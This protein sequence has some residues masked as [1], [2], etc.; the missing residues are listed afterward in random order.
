MSTSKQ[1]VSPSRSI[2]KELQF[3]LVGDFGAALIMGLMTSLRW[4]RDRS[5]EQWRKLAAI[6]RRFGKVIFAFWHSQLLMPAYLGRNMGVRILISA[7]EDGEYIARVVARLGFEP[8]R[9]SAT[10]GGARA[11]RELALAG[12]ERDL[13]VT[14][15]GPVGPR[16]HV[17]PG[18]IMLAQVSGLPIV[19][20][21][22]VARHSIRAHS[23][24]RFEVPL[25]GS[26][27]AFIVGDPMRVDPDIRGEARQ[28]ACR[29]LERTL[30]ELTD[31]VR[32]MVGLGP[33][34]GD[35]ECRTKKD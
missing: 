2:V 24:D 3:E 10:R 6:R 34:N 27:A 13:A 29:Q 5:H 21:A 15:D 32:H 11:L 17:Q 20:I 25:P 16:H 14:P 12:R 28:Q 26:P 22:G 19:P 33:E 1:P 31:R 7:S 4:K 35:A 9:G 18:S 23:W 8:V 30:L